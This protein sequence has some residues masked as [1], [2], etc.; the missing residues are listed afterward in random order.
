MLLE[1]IIVP[2]IVSV[3]HKAGL[4]G[5]ARRLAVSDVEFERVVRYASTVRDIPVPVEHLPQHSGVLGKVKRIWREGNVGMAELD[6][7]APT[8]DGLGFLY[9]LIR[10]NLFPFD[11]SLHHE[12]ESGRVLEISLCAKGA[13]DGSAIV[14]IDGVPYIQGGLKSG[15]NRN[16]RVAASVMSAAAPVPPS[17]PAPAAAAAAAAPAVG[18]NPPAAGPAAAE[19]ADQAAPSLMNIRVESLESIIA[20]AGP[21]LSDEDKE[22][23]YMT[24]RARRAEEKRIEEAAEARRKA[25]ADDNAS[26][27]LTLIGFIKKV[28][29]DDFDAT[30]IE[31]ALQ[32]RPLD[33]VL[34]SFKSELVAASNLV[35]SKE[36]RTAR[37]LSGARDPPAQSRVAAPVPQR[38]VVSRA[39]PDSTDRSRLIAALKDTHAGVPETVAASAASAPPASANPDDNL[40]PALRYFKN[41]KTEGVHVKRLMDLE[42]EESNAR[43]ARY[44]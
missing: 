40:P 14:R 10:L 32:K 12:V 6:L 28:R 18:A 44:N 27:L 33:E 24:V 20:K 39:N 30:A 16:T 19:Q 15:Y 42:I 1:V 23:L 25:I 8:I 3:R 29:G 17:N 11:V 5:E 22:A 43:R 4:V 21:H 13:R 2:D 38:V 34:G 37:L 36:A 7:P 26:A 31:E 41:F 35:E 9:R